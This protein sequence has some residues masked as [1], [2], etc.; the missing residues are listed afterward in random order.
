LGPPPAGSDYFPLATGDRWV[1][2]ETRYNTTTAYQYDVGATSSAGDTSSTEIVA[3]AFDGTVVDVSR[4]T[5]TSAGVTVYASPGDTYAAAVGPYLM[6][7]LPVAPGDSF[8]QVDKTV[9]LGSDQDGDGVNEKVLVLSTVQAIARA[10]VS[11]PAGRFADA[12]HLRTTVRQTV[13]YSRDGS[14]W[15]SEDVVDDWYV[16]GVGRVRA[17]QSASYNGDLQPTRSTVLLAYRTAA[18]H[19]GASPTV[20]S[21]APDDTLVHD[22]GVAVTATFDAPMDAASLGAGGF[23]VVDAGGQAVAGTVTTAADGLSAAFVP[24]AG[25]HSGVFTATV[26]AAA[27]DREGNAATPRS[28]IVNIDTVAPTLAQAQPADGST[29]VA[30]DTTLRFVFSEPLEWTT[31]MPGWSP[32]F[33]I[34]DDA[35]GAPAPAVLAFD[36]QATITIAPR[37]YWPHGHAYTVTFPSTFTDLVGNPMGVAR[38]VR[39]SITPGVFADPTPLATSLGTFPSVTIGDV[40]GDGRPDIVWAAWDSTVFPWQMRLFLRRGLA[41]GSFAAPVEP[42]AAPA[43]PCNLVTMAIGDT[44]GDGRS[45]LVMGGNCGIRVLLQGT[46]GRF[47]QGPVYPLPGYDYGGVVK[48]VDLD[49]DGRLDM[50]TAGNSSG[51]RVW[52]QTSPGVFTETA[53]IETGLGSVTGL[54]LADLDG[55][56]RVDVVATSAGSQQDRLAVLHGLGSGG[57]GAAVP[58]GTGADGWPSGVGIADMDGDGRL[59][60]VVSIRGGTVPRVVVLRQGADR[61]F[62]LAS[63]VAVSSDPYGMALVDTDNDGRLDLVVG[64][65][66]ALAVMARRPDGSFGAEDLYG[67]TPLAS[68]ASSMAVGPRDAQGRVVIEYSGLVFGPKV[69]ASAASAPMT[70]TTASVSASASAA[71]PVRVA[72]PAGSPVRTARPARLFDRVPVALRATM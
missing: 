53:M 15:S 31:V 46:D 33:T 21:H 10:P 52:M 58:V 41:D 37:T 59:D 60:I 24:A 27:T 17:D 13:V 63:T 6:L 29:D 3:S 72:P 5:S 2:Q 44:N 70:R 67:V 20:T 28:W 55:D 14:R 54:D 62:S 9:D 1:Y 8:I 47:S 26:S 4:Y 38:K 45:D 19:G 56:G 65:Y 66:D 64:L 30:T 34:T 39:F 7:T 71:G 23:A 48:L 61:G 25:W 12:L 35:T 11:T 36:G 43:Y 69:A 32:A 42:I 18:G 51:F 68:G 40:D 49:G 22:G 16:A 50:L 57:F